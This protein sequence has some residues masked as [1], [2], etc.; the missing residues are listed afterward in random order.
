[1][2]VTVLFQLIIIKLDIFFYNHVF[3]WFSMKRRHAI[4]VMADSLYYTKF[5]LYCRVSKLLFAMV[6]HTVG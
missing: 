1:M 2:M 4:V 5:K 6:S 3:Q